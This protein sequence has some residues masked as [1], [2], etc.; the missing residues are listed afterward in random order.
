MRTYRHTLVVTTEDPGFASHVGKLMRA[1]GQG[2]GDLDDSIE[3]EY[4]YETV[5]RPD[6]TEV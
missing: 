5:T 1:M 3:A 2:L 6:D 4:L